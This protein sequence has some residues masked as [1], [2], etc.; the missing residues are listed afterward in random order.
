MRRLASVALGTRV[1]SASTET[2]LARLR[3]RL[4][5]HYRGHKRW[6]EKNRMLENKIRRCALGTCGHKSAAA[7]MSALVQYVPLNPRKKWSWRNIL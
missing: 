7:C 4:D 5:G 1:A 3:S 2:E 6:Y